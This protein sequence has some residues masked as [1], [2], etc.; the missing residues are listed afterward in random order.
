M[1]VLQPAT[2]ILGGCTVKNEVGQDVSLESLWRGR[3]TLFIFLRHFACL[4]CRA[5]AVQMLEGRKALE[6]RGTHLVFIGNG[7]PRFI[8]RFKQELGVSEAEVYTDPS[9]AVFQAAGFKRGFLV[10]H[11][12]RSMS[13]VAKLLAKGFVPDVPAKGFG[14]MWQLGG[15]ML[16]SSSG[17]ILYHF[18][19]QAQGDFPPERDLAAA[20]EAEELA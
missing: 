14:D 13:N 19:S 2:H 7:H 9:L 5:H 8:R 4:A 6:A 1:I 10:S 3:R 12:P 17:R 16:I 18:I 11:G 20:I 15:A